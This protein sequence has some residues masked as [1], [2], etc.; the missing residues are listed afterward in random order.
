MVE[1]V[2]IL[3]P[4]GT[5]E[6]EKSLSWEDRIVIIDERIRYSFFEPTIPRNFLGNRKTIK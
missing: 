5:I 1:K 3:V 6:S 2:F 4:E